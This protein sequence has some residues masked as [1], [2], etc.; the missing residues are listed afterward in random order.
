MPTASLPLEPPVQLVVTPDR[1]LVPLLDACVRYVRVRIEAPVVASDRPRMPVDLAFVLD[2]SGSMS[3]EPIALVRRAVSEALGRLSPSDRFAIYTFDSEVDELQGLVAASAT[4][5]STARDALLA[6]EAGSTT[7]LSGGWSAG[8]RA[9]GAVVNLPSRGPFG[10]GIGAPPPREVTPTPAEGDAE[11]IVRARRAVVL[12][13]GRAN[14]GV[15]DLDQLCTAA[16]A[17]AQQGV[18]TSTLGFGDHFDEAFLTAL[19]DAGRGG[20][21]YVARA[22]EIPAAVAR[23]VGEALEVVARVPSLRVT[24]PAGATVRC[25]ASFPCSV[26]G[27]EATVALSDLTS[28]QQLDVLLEV[29]L[30]GAHGGPQELAATLVVDGQPAASGHLAWVPSSADAVADEKP[31]ALVLVAVATRI[32]AL[33]R[34]A[35]VKAN[36]RHDYDAARVILARAVEDVVALNYDS[37]DMYALLRGLDRDTSEYTSEM[38]EYARKTSY[39]ASSSTLKDRTSSGTSR[40]RTN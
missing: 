29:R 4:A 37:P 21:F 40:K 28:G 2:R 16:T 17:V 39:S 6:V 20:F 38:T 24:L 1:S 23:E 12:T 36:Q 8:C 31:D 10:H 14:R 27:N 18:G 22:D 30:A 33:A 25:L 13:D 35:A 19:S 32:V 26:N 11:G 7:H 3:G 9:L 34:L 5:V 15:T